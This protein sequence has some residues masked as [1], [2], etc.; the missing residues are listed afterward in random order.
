MVL[1]SLVFHYNIMYLHE[2]Y[3]VTSHYFVQKLTMYVCH[4]QKRVITKKII[5]SK[6]NGVDVLKVYEI[7]GKFIEMW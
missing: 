2:C 6:Q 5:K 4:L 1:V 7:Q 3:C